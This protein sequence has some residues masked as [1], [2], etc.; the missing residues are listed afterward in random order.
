MGWQEDAQTDRESYW[1]IKESREQF[2]C[3][4]KNWDLYLVASF[5]LGPVSKR[6]EIALHVVNHDFGLEL[7]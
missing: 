2:K 1:P 7:S 6:W 4:E 3:K 5:M